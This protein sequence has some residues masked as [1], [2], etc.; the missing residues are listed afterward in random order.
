M[1][2]DIV[3]IENDKGVLMLAITKNVLSVDLSLVSMK[4]DWEA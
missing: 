2:L 1:S 4:L 3:V